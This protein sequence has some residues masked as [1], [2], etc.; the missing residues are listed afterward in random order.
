MDPS[1][2]SS[3]TKAPWPIRS[4]TPRNPAGP[5]PYSKSELAPA[6]PSSDT[7]F[8]SQPRI[9]THIDDNAIETLSKYYADV[10][11]RRGKILD[12]CSSWVSHYP[13]VTDEA[14]R[15]GECE[16]W[17][18]G[19]NETELR[20]NS[21]LNLDGNE[22]WTVQDLNSNPEYQLPSSLLERA[23]ASD[24]K[25]PVFDASTCTVSVDYL[26]SPVG[27]L[28][29]IGQHTVPGGT[30]HLAISNRCFPTKAV[31]RWLRISEKERLEMV[32]DYLWWAGWR[33]VEIVTLVD[34]NSAHGGEGGGWM[35]MMGLGHKDPLWVVRAKKLGTGEEMESSGGL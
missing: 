29:S 20:R 10:L 28:H 11:P 32:G 19:M 21:L 25:S 22:R 4:Y 17:G 34:P 8:Y 12:F 13:A 14:V 18:T 16:V 2:S 26:T 5:F 1:S 15:K 7:G 24:D 33:E 31:S 6:D 3:G 23:P 35:A 27:V 30:V 9:V